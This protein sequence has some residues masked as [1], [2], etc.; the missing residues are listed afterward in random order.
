MARLKVE[1]SIDERSGSVR[2]AYTEKEFF[3]KLQQRMERL[4]SVRLFDS[5]MTVCNCQKNELSPGCLACKAG[6]WICVFPGFECNAIC[7]FCPR[8]TSANLNERMDPVQLDILFALIELRKERITG[9]SISGG[10]LFFRNLATAKEIIRRMKA[11]Y[12]KVYLWGYTNGIFAT[13]DNLQELRDLGLDEI[14]FNLAATDFDAGI[15]ETVERHAVPI[16]PWVT[17]E[18][19]SYEKSYVRLVKNGRLRDLADMGVRQLNLAEI[20]VPWPKRRTT[21]IPP[22]TREF[23]GKRDL[24]EYSDVLGERYLSLAESR[25][26]TCDVIDFAHR[27]GIALRINDC[28]QEAKTLQRFARIFNGLR[29]V[30]AVANAP[31]ENLSK[32]EWM[33]DLRPRDWYWRLAERHPRL[34]WTLALGAERLLLLGRTGALLRRARKAGGP[35]SVLEGKAVGSAASRRGRIQDPECPGER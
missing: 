19:P 1:G 13:R 35:G 26:Y 10:E 23:F 15:L 31:R 28:S 16:F 29:A 6:G 22:A 7:P 4:E 21:E 33:V 17:V 18:V 34:C 32:R 24:Y 11:R 2:Q 14:R 9:L 25:F 30:Q 8:L 5:G 27:H 3:E 12:P 20:R